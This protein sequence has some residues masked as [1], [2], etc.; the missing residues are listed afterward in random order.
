MNASQES[1]YGMTL[2]V[3]KHT[4][5]HLLEVHKLFNAVQFLCQ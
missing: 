3:G 5:P 2:A 1:G 4:S